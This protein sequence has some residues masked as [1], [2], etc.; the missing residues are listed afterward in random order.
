MSKDNQIQN[1]LLDFQNS[2]SIK[3]GS[4]KMQKKI[5]R[6][7]SSSTGASKRKRERPVIQ[8]IQT[9]SWVPERETE[10]CSGSKPLTILWTRGSVSGKSTALPRKLLSRGTVTGLKGP[11]RVVGIPPW[12]NLKLTV[13][14]MN[15]ATVGNV[16]KPIYLFNKLK[17]TQIFWMGLEERGTKDLKVKEQVEERPTN[18]ELKSAW[19]HL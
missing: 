15:S 10:I 18:L 2:I 6:N 7:G 8:D 11:S 16:N 14:I 9:E 1:W 4:V 5:K 17:P 19:G 12:T 3:L 13:R